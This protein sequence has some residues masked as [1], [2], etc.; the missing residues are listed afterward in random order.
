VKIEGM[1]DYE[2][3]V[4]PLSVAVMRVKAW[5]K[6]PFGKGEDKIQLLPLRID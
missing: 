2:T 1:G 5:M 6:H 3:E 4:L